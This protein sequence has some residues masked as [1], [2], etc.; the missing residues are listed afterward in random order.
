MVDACAWNAPGADPYR[1]PVAE[2]VAAAV[3]RYDMT[4]QA[5][6]ELVQ[7][8]RLLQPDGIIVIQRDG[9]TSTDGVATDLKDMHFGKPGRVCKGLVVRDKWRD[10][11]AETALVYC[12]QG[13]CIAVPTIC[14]NVSRV[15]WTPITPPKEPEFR[16]WQGNPAPAPEF[17]PGPQAGD[18]RSE[19]QGRGAMRLQ[20]RDPSHP[21]T[22]VPEPSS[23]LLVGAALALLA[24]VRRK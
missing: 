11:Q 7:K 23:A 22:P 5:R 1:G 4:T 18:G 3:Q 17:G 13:E 24:W 15:T 8:A 10:N 2:S 6:A 21:Q 14:G 20:Q 19:P 16:G 12:A 9:I